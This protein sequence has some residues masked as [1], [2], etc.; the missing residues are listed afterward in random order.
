MRRAM[1]VCAVLAAISPT[2]AGAADRVWRMSVLALADDG[3]TR[4]TDKEIKKTESV[5]ALAAMFSG[6]L[7]NGL[8]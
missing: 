4:R 5:A 2:Y 3:S 8:R 6:S 1:L 7:A